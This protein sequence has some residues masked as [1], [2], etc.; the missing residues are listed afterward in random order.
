[1]DAD[2]LVKASAY[3]TLRTACAGQDVEAEIKAFAREKLAQYKCPR[4]V[5]VLPELPK[6][7]TGKIQRFLLRG[8]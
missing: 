1:M 2:G 8:G 3:V 6:T 7:A 4:R 5:V